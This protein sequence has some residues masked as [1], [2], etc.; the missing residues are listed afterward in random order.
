MGVAYCHLDAGGDVDSLLG[1][2]R[3]IGPEIDTVAPAVFA[4]VQKASDGG[5]PEGQQHYW[6]SGSLTDLTEDAIATMFDYVERMPSPSSGIGFQQLHGAAARV[7]PTATAYPHRWTRYDFLI[8]SQWGD[9]GVTT[10]NVRW[11]SDFF[12]AMGPFFD[13]GLYVNNL[14]DEGDGRVRQAYGPNYE[15][16]VAIKSVYDPTN[17]FRHDHNIP[18]RDVRADGAL[19]RPR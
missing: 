4:D 12:D 10:D 15:R 7:E 5:F 9:P 11:T 19:H 1:G 17:L 8:L 2:L 18:P 13:R 14:G 16:L 6:K 3:R